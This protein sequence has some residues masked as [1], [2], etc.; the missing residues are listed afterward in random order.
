MVK[1]RIEYKQMSVEPWEF[2]LLGWLRDPVDKAA[3][4]ESH[5]A[6]ARQYAAIVMGRDVT[7]NSVG[8]P[9][10]QVASTY[11]RLPMPSSAGDMPYVGPDDHGNLLVFH[12]LSAEPRKVRATLDPV[13]T[14]EKLRALMDDEM[15]LER[16]FLTLWRLA[17]DRFPETPADPRCPDHT[18]WQHADTTAAIAWATEFGSGTVALLSFK[19]SPVQPFIEA[20]RSLRDLLSGSY[21]LSWLCFAAMV[22]VLRACGPTALVYPALRGIP[23]MDWWLEKHGVAVKPDTAKLARASLPNRFL[24]IVPHALA[25][26]LAAEV[27]NAA[28]DAWLTAADDVHEQLRRKYDAEFPRWDRLWDQQIES[29]F[30]FCCTWL[31]PGDANSA[32]LLGNEGT[33]NARKIT[34]LASASF[35]HMTRPGE[36][37]SAVELSAGLMRATG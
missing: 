3:D 28:R 5:R 14:E 8:G 7:E 18:L 9:S 11:G 26:G 35:A 17:P 4:I 10:Y 29:Y 27:R 30:N 36:W 34:K 23:L 6:R 15:T 22:P 32:D 25:A 16:Q 33:D 1:C 37:Q 20:S 21:L 12:P 13:A 2:L 31:I 24:A 19:L